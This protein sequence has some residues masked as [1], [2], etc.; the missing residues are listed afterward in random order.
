MCCFFAALVF[1]G[2]RVGILIWWLIN[3]LYFQSIF[4]GWILPLLGFIILPWTMLMY[5]A[6]APGGIIGFDWIILGL[7]VLADVA[8][9]S[10]SAYGNR[11][12]I[13]GM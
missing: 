13:P 6:I 10:G 8:S 4:D 1:L 7:G 12:R 3:P 11:D 9:Y 5:I 2:P